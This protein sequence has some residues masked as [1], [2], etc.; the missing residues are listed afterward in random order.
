MQQQHG[1]SAI[2]FTDTEAQA[3]FRATGPQ[4]QFLLDS[5][6]FKVFLVGLQAGQ[7]LPAQAE[8]LAL[9]HFLEGQGTMTVDEQTYPIVAG[10]TLIALPGASRGMSAETQLVFLAAMSQ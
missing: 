5:E 1:L 4:P 8:A 9:Y 3:V 7:Q 2:V 10:T 6:H